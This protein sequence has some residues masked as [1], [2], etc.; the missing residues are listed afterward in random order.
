M[1]HNIQLVDLAGKPR[2]SELAGHTGVVW[3]IAVSKDGKQ[4]V[5][6]GDDHTV[7]LWTVR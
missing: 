2:G 4:L 3:S 1:G 6:C 7:R 5:S